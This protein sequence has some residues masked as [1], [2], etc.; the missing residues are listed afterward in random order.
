MSIDVDENARQKLY[1]HKNI[2]QG[3]NKNGTR[4]LIL[5]LDISEYMAMA[6]RASKCTVLCTAHTENIIAAQ[7]NNNNVTEKKTRER[8]WVNAQLEP[9]KPK[10]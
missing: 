9:K 8:E 2:E 4:T 7:M 3:D 6:K 1:T 10:W 5:S